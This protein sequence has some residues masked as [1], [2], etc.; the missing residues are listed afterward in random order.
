MMHYFNYA[1]TILMDDAPM[2]FL[3]YGSNFRL[4]NSRV[5]HLENPLLRNYDLTQVM[6]EKK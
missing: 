5:K 3:Y 2:V 4:M 1:E 6:I